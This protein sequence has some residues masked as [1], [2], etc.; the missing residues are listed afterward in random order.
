MPQNGP[1]I[2][3]CY[4][5]V[6][7]ESNGRLIVFAGPACSG[8]TELARRL[9]LRLHAPHLQM[10]A[11][12]ARLMPDSPHTRPDRRVAYRAMLFAAELLLGCGQTVILDAPY[13]H[14]EDRHDIRC[15]VRTARPAFYVIECTVAPAIAA[16]RFDQR[17]PDHPGLDLTRERVLEMARTYPTWGLGLR[18]DTGERSPAEC[19]RAIEEYVATTGVGSEAY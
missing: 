17:P 19:S 18:I 16:H 6:V 10:D 13:G 4:P 7:P 2:P 12:R 1:Q 9:A 14:A 11:T 15:L 5:G 8:K 3:L